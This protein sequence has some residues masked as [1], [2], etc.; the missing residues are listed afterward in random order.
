MPTRSI[1]IA[2]SLAQKPGRGGHTWVFLQYLLGFKQLGWDVLFV[3]SLEPEM[4]VDEAGARA[5]VANSWNVRYL[6]DVMRRFDLGDSFAL[7]VDGGSCT[8]GMSRSALLERVRSSSALI[9]V[10]GYLQDEEVLAAAA[11][12]VFLDIDPGF[13]Q[14]WQELGL[15]DAFQGH[16]AF[17]TIGERVGQPSCAVPTCG[18][19]WLTTR[20]PVVL[21]Q[22]PAAFAD[23]AACPVTSVVSWRGAYG[24]VTYQGKEYGLRPREFRKFAGLPK[25][26][27][28]C[29]ELALDIH[30]ADEPDR[31]LLR[32]N[33]WMLVPAREV[34]GDPWTYRDYIRN[35][36]AEVM[37]AKNMYVESGSGW[38][39]DRSICYLASGRP[40]V[41]QDTG[42]AGL[43]PT[44]E[45]LLTFTTLDEATEAVRAVRREPARHQRAARRLAEEYFDSARILRAF[46]EKLGLH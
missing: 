32:T 1:A 20:Q 14:M 41:A 7:L 37:I 15:H 11:T 22:W 2:G 29:F 18:L 16:D 44:G 36:A 38:V 10:M 24:P 42:L 43:L 26:A 17:V 5:T 40:V 27:G 21:D 39:S 19:D 28:G 3:D 33:G 12:R 9:N 34:T 23:L 6:T 35:S 31:D 46:A 25:R 13:G 4:C 8:I 30:P 45:G